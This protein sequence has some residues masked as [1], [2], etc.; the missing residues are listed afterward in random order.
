MKNFDARRPA[1]LRRNRI[2]GIV[3]LLMLILLCWLCYRWYVRSVAKPAPGGGGT[4]NVVGTPDSRNDSADSSKS[5]SAR[6][7]A[8]AGRSD[9]S[10]RSQESSEVVVTKDLELPFFDDDAWVIVNKQGRYVLMYDTLYRQASWVAYLLTSSDID[11]KKVERTN[12]FIP[13]PAVVSRGFP[14][15]YTSH[16][17]GSGYDRGHLCPSADRAGSKDENKATFYLSNISPQTPALNRGIWKRLEEQVRDW[18]LKYDSVYVATGGVLSEGLNTISGGVG[19]PEYFYKAL[20]TRR[21]GRFYSIGFIIPNAKHFSTDMTYYA[22]SIDSLQR[23]TSI[24]FFHNLPDD[25]EMAV[26][27][28]CPTEF[29]F[30]GQ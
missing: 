10:H 2:I 3:I 29:W 22:V 21:N 14:T 25:I 20:L 18:A 23:F 1:R 24:D 26:E 6:S 19:V 9:S 28:V 17:T 7:E 5:G 11:T 8:S 4:E 12:N 30:G 15:A 13:D 27:S 16:Y